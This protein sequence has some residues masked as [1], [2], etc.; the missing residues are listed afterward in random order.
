MSIGSMAEIVSLRS[1][2]FVPR[3]ALAGFFGQFMR[4]RRLTNNPRKWAISERRT[5]QFWPV[6]WPD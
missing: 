4:H 6:L 3:A 5:K 1:G 2:D